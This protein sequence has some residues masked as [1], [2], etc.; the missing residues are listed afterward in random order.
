ML[1]YKRRNP[2]PQFQHFANISLLV[3]MG[4]YLVLAWL[5]RKTSPFNCVLHRPEIGNLFFILSGYFD[6]WKGLP[7]V[8]LTFLMYLIF[9]EYERDFRQ[10]SYY[11]KWISCW[12]MQASF[13]YISTTSPFSLFYLYL[14]SNI[15]IWGSSPKKLWF[16]SIL[17]CDP[18]CVTTIQWYFLCEFHL[19]NIDF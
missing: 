14:S 10:V 5:H 17:V 11:L 2:G 7:N 4:C 12:I 13:S 3:S 1:V 18:E 16:C 19:F 15:I 6:V 9:A 8:T